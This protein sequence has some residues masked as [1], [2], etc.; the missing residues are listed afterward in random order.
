MSVANTSPVGPTASA[1]F[2]LIFE[3]VVVL[4]ILKFLGFRVLDYTRL[5]ARGE[6]P[7]P[8]RKDLEREPAREVET[9]EFK[10]VPRQ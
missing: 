6:I 1:M 7:A 3:G 9:G 10:A 4:S 8:S 2:V 5:V